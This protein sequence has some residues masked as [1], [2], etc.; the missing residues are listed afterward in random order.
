MYIWTHGEKTLSGKI[1]S[2]ASGLRISGS[3]G[4]GGKWGLKLRKKASKLRNFLIETLKNFLIETLKKALRGGG[5]FPCLWRGWFAVLA[6]VPV[7]PLISPPFFNFFL[8]FFFYLVF[9]FFL[10]LIFAICSI[11]RSAGGTIRPQR[12]FGQNLH[13][14]I[15]YNCPNPKVPNNKKNTYFD[16]CSIRSISQQGVLCEG[17]HVYM[18]VGVQAGI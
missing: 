9:T 3:K 2:K 13:N 16:H 8:P 1:L 15:T 18:Y 6:G 10:N 5:K 14:E 11:G 7:A 17:S 4:G 12:H